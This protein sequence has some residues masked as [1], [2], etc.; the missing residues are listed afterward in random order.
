M[1]PL[2]AR[3]KRDMEIVVSSSSTSWLPVTAKV[4]VVKDNGVIIVGPFT[5][6]PEQQLTVPIDAGKWGVLIQSDWNITASVWID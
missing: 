5:V 1:N 4:W 2:P 6:V 3:E